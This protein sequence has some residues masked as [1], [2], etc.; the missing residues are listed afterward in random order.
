[1]AASKYTAQDVYDEVYC[2]NWQEVERI[3]TAQP[4]ILTE[5]YNGVTSLRHIIYFYPCEEFIF[6]ILTSST[7]QEVEEQDQEGQFST[8]LHPLSVRGYFKSIEYVLS[9]SSKRVNSPDENGS[10]PLHWLLRSNLPFTRH[11]DSAKALLDAGADVH[12]YNNEGSTP[13][14]KY[15]QNLC[16]K[17]NNGTKDKQ[18]EELLQFMQSYAIPGVILARG[19]EAV[20]VFREELETG[21]ITVNHARLMITGKEGVGKTS[22]VNTLLEKPFNERERSTDGIALTTAFHADSEKKWKEHKDLDECKRLQEIYDEKLEANVADK[23]RLKATE[24]DPSTISETVST[25]SELKRPSPAITEEKDTEIEKELKLKTKVTS[26]QIAATNQG[27]TSEN[28]VSSIQQLRL[29][30]NK[31]EDKQVLLEKDCVINESNQKLSS[32]MQKRI[33]NKLKGDTNMFADEDITYIWDFAGQPLYYIT[34]RIFL[35]SEA[36]YVITF[37]LKEGMYD[38]ANSIEARSSTVKKD[39]QDMTCNMTNV[40]V[41]KYWMKL[42][43]TYAIPDGESQKQDKDMK[44]KK[45]QILVVGTHSRS[46]SGTSVENDKWIQDQFNTLFQEIEDTPYECHVIRK[47]YTIDNKYPLES[48]TML[49]S[50]KHD[51]SGF[52]KAFPKQIPLKWLQLQRWI[53]EIGKTKVR[54]PYHDVFKAAAEYGITPENLIHT[55]QYMHDIGTVL[56]FAKH[57]LLKDT[58]ITSPRKLITILKRIIT[59]VKPGD[60]LP[61]MVKLWRK[62]E[63]EGILHEE[64]A[65]HVW[66]EELESDDSNFEVFLELMKQFGLLCEQVKKNH[67]TSRSFF[68][69][70]RLKYM[71]RCMS[72]ERDPD[73]VVSVY[74]ASNDFLPDSIFHL[75]VVSLIEMTQE[76]E[77]T[78]H[79]P[80]LFSNKITVC[81]EHDHDLSLGQVTISNKYA[82]KLAISRVPEVSEDGT[83]MTTGQPCPVICMQALEFLK[84][85]LKVITSGMKRTGY[86]FLVLCWR[87]GC[88]KN[89]FYKLGNCLKFGNVRCGG[90]SIKTSKLQRLFNNRTPDSESQGKPATLIK[91]D[92]GRCSGYLDD[93]HLYNLAKQIGSTYWQP[94]AIELGFTWTEVQNFECDNKTVSGR[95]MDMLS[96]WR[97]RQTEVTN[98]VGVMYIAL[99]EQGLVE[100]AE[101]M[102]RNASAM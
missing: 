78:T 24:T 1:M 56:Y 37:N 30:Q 54:I 57:Q 47:C 29:N 13:V 16:R 85:E 79:A 4:E 28:T 34:H 55:L 89:H 44:V 61:T 17:Y 58:V 12:I 3:I 94:L 41:I 25:I 63:N 67:E 87:I 53:K 90:K 75:L 35:T 73:H 10:T 22:L 27:A 18:K 77:C 48:D 42:I 88:Q 33:I 83:E 93:K 9:I 6:K 14:D 92:T 81:L 38:K 45:P 49:N 31:V 40:E 97:K 51:V 32:E 43:Y 102:Q 26:Q 71:E 2:A 68:V 15:I 39:H 59:Y 62:L 100:V 20:R 52:L 91:S 7:P 66:Q 74:I 46:L 21:Q 60:K 72:I 86:E 69:P 11:R 80:T 65:R 8:I 99:K 50:L 96:S 5:R 76:K 82:L 84:Q 19:K 70:C 64:L 23:L 101:R 98:Q 36:V 95:I